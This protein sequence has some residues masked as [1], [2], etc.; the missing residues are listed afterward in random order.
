MT[1]TGVGDEL[2]DNVD[3]EAPGADRGAF[4][5]CSPDVSVTAIPGF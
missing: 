4:T 2:W 5:W 1:G 3:I